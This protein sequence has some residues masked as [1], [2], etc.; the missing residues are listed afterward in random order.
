MLDVLKSVLDE[1]CGVNIRHQLD[2]N[3]GMRG[4]KFSLRARLIRAL[5][6][7]IR[8]RNARTQA[9]MLH[10][11][12]LHTAMPHAAVPHVHS[13][14]LHWLTILSDARHS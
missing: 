13:A 5:I 14:K 2:R 3:L 1:G 7:Q 4:L 6:R 11:A 10:T 9:A 8:A 12:M